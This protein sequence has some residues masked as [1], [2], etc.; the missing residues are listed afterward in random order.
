MTLNTFHHAG[1]GTFGTATLGVPRVKELLS[2]SKN[3]KTPVMF[4]YLDKENR[5]KSDMANKIGSY[6]KSTTMK[7]IRRKVNI[8]YDPNPL[9]DTGFMKSD[10]VYNVF[11]SHT[12]TKN[13]CQA[14][15]TSLPWL[16]RIEMD[17][18]KMMEKDITLLDIK[19]K[20][21]NQWEK[22]YAD[23]KGLKKEERVLLERISQ[24][25]ILSNS[26]ND[27]TPIV[28]IRFD[29]VEFDFSTLVSFLD[30]FI[31]N[32]KLK[33]IDSINKID[34]IKEE[35]VVSFDNDDEGLTKENQYVIYTSGVNMI[36]IRYINGIDINKTI[37]NDIVEIYETF[38]I[39][40][41]RI[42][43]LREF[44]SVFANA[45][46]NVNYQH[47]EILV[48]I[49]TNSGHL[50]SIDRHGMN[51]SE[52]DPLARASFEKTVDQL[53]QAAVFGEV[54]YMKSV[55]SRIMAGLVIKGG[56]G[57]CNIILNSD[58]LEKSEYIEDIEQKY[59]KTFNEVS[60]SSVITDVINKDV[61]G[62]FIPD[63]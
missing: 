38:G 33:G 9:K 37:S 7:D 59:V 58:L 62:I 50:T 24:V 45:G 52:S 29:M 17:R 46:T 2:L 21:C 57:L 27:K 5:K 28:H 6:I 14:D 26:E 10:G 39:D 49:I 30:T 36:D 8:Y 54:D 4:I 1:I 31:D 60:T 3:I 63:D 35:Q 34:Y 32:F 18:E 53:I 40:A 20:F 23:T 15:A 25:S 55:S 12:P 41:A 51:K 47:L 13:S 11:Y 22:R 56:T 44:K 43:L 48:D 42:A 16:L 61:S 19:A